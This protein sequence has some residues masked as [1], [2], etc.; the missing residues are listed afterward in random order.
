[1][2]SKLKTLLAIVLLLTLVV[3]FFAALLPM[4]FDKIGLVT[5]QLYDFF[6]QLAALCFHFVF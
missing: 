3:S 4:L 2:N 5:F 6:V 1:V